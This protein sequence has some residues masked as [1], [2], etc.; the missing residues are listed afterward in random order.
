MKNQYPVKINPITPDALE[1]LH[2]RGEGVLFWQGEFKAEN[3]GNC[4]FY[5][6]RFEDISFIN[7]LMQG[8]SF[9]GSVFKHVSFESS[10]LSG[11]QFNCGVLEQVNFKN[12]DLSGVNLFRAKL[13]QCNFTKADMTGVCFQE[14]DFTECDF[15]GVDLSNGAIMAANSLMGCLY[16]HTTQLP[17]SKSEAASRGMVYKASHLKVVSEDLESQSVAEVIDFS[18]FKK[19]TTSIEPKTVGG[20]VIQMVD[21]FKPKTTNGD[22]GPRIA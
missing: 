22:D 7:N 2:G 6:C 4:S 11:V 12:A 5:H 20:E 8:I 14:A 17:F 1:R 9:F 19:P 13:F 15:R 16:D 18:K 21:Y 3:W 10:C